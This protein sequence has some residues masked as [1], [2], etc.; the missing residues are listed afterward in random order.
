MKTNTFLRHRRTYLPATDFVTQ[1]SKKYHAKRFWIWEILED[2]FN[3][4][5]G[6]GWVMTIDERIKAEDIILRLI[7]D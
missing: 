3:M 6:H 4:L 5:K 2:Y 7:E 1:M